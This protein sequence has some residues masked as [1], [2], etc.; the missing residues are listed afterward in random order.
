MDEVLKLEDYLIRDSYRDVVKT[1]TTKNCEYKNSYELTL[2]VNDLLNDRKSLKKII[3]NHNNELN[4]VPNVDDLILEDTV[5]K[6]IFY[7]ENWKQKNYRYD[8]KMSNLYNNLK[9]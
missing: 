3:D 7:G 1:W 4:K 6:H 8:K 2:L 5:Q 9:K